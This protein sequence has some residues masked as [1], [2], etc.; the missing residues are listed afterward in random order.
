MWQPTLLCHSLAQCLPANAASQSQRQATQ[1]NADRQVLAGNPTG[2]EAFP[3]AKYDGDRIPNRPYLFA[4]STLRLNWT[5]VLANFD[6]LSAT[7]NFRFVEEYD[8]IWESVG[9]EEFKQVVPS[10][11]I[12]SFGL[13]YTRDLFPY[14]FNVTAE[15]QNL[16]NN[17]LYDFYG[18]QRPGR[19]FYLKGTFEF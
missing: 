13:T 18:V 10:Q 16:T 3:I 6:E 5:N 7:W 12:H 9:I 11:E 4:N 8:L 14:T 19:A 15:V 1:C 17:K 2:F